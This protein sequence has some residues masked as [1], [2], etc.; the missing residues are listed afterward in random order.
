[1]MKKI[2]GILMLCLLSCNLH[3]QPSF[4]CNKAISNVEITICNSKKLSDLDK[5]LAQIY[6]EA[7]HA[8]GENSLKNLLE[9]QRMWLRL[10]NQCRDE[11]CL[12]K[13]YEFRIDSICLLES[14]GAFL[15]CQQ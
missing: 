11:V 1:M 6:K 13:A 5:Y 9:T 14:T 8:A 10:R 2:I 7:R 15:I 12:I 4:D 3:S